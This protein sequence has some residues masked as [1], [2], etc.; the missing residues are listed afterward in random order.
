MSEISPTLHQSSKQASSIVISQPMGY[1]G[2]IILARSE[3]KYVNEDL[4]DL[5]TTNQVQDTATSAD[6]AE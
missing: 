4:S 2:R 5:A 1:A 6:S 3:R